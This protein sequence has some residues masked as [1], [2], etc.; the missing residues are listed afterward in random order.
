MDSYSF[1]VGGG[2]GGN[3]Q[4]RSQR[5]SANSGDTASLLHPL[6]TTTT[7]TIFTDYTTRTITVFD[8]VTTWL[9]LTGAC[10]PDDGCAGVPARV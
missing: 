2:L 4:D 3:S 1:T 6:T 8:D 9:R 10:D 5:R 7:Q